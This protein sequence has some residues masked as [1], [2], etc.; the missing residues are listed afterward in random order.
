[1]NETY[2]TSLE[3]GAKLIRRFVK[4]LPDT[5]GVYR[6]LDKDGGVLYVGKAKSLKKRVVSYANY[7][8]LP[9]RLQRMVAAT[10]DMVFV[11]THTEVEALLLE[12]NLIKKLKPRYN[13]LLRDD[14]SF[15]YILIT[16]DHD[17]P[18]LTKHRG[19]RKRKGDYFGP[20]ASAG[21]VNRTL[22]ALQKAFM[23]RNCTD[24]YFENRSRPCLQYHIKRCTA[25]CVAKVST[26]E[27]A[28]QVK[29]AQN[30]LS[31]KSQGVQEELAQEMQTASDALDYERAA[32]LRDRIKALTAIQAKQDINIAMSG[33]P[34]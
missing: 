6:M 2:E 25:P 13:V 29:Q 17:F 26:E 14:K 10:K 9:L 32:A 20:F 1:M 24:S 22:T 8:K 7:G 27:Y 16:G 21:A 5:P 3:Q 23:L 12:S 34:M 33:M 19:A 11:H 30:F 28:A 18:L 4:T 15:P 31:G